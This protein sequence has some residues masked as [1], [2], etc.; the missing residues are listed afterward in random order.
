MAPQSGQEKKENAI[1]AVIPLA[2]SAFEAARRFHVLKKA[3]WKMDAKLSTFGN[4]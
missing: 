2:F 3:S 4:F 1:Q